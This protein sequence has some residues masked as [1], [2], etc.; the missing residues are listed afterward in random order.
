MKNIW[1]KIETTVN[2][3]RYPNL[4]FFVFIKKTKK[5][6]IQITINLLIMVGA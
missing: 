5:N 4:Y 6:G 3:F 2:S 1:E